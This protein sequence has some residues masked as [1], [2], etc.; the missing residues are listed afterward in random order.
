MANL[1]M[2]EAAQWFLS[3]DNYLI[4]THRRPDGDTVGCSGAL[5]RALR[6]LG[7]TAHILENP[8]LTQNYAAHHQ[9][10]TCSAPPATSTVVTVDVAGREMLCK[11][12]E[13]LEIDFF[14]DHHGSNK[15]LAPQG[16]LRPEDAACGQ[17][18][19]DLVRALGVPLDRPMAEALYVA[20]S[21]DTGCFRYSNTTAQT[22]R[23]A[24]ACLEAGADVYP[25]N[26]SLF[27]TVTMARLRLNAYMAQHL[28]LLREGRIALCRIPLEVERELGIREEDMEN[29]SSFARN[30][31][32]VHMAATFRTT[33]NGDTKLSLRSSPAYDVAQVAVALGGGGHKAAAGVTLHGNQALARE[34]L[35]A[36][37]REQEIL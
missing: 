12:A 21:T 11:G 8:Q 26:Q 30:V 6:A 29:V 5:C 22:L 37:L 4:V 13:G 35:L 19:Y 34:K 24:A 28:E 18:V 23:V 33:E 36:V 20:V 10:L 14:I 15:G 27:E 2:N 1:T 9:G 32:G 16:L 25:I 17:I 31:E 7:K 3:R